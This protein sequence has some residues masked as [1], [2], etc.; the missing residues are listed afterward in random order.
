MAPVMALQSAVSILARLGSRALL[1]ARTDHAHEFMFQSSPD[2][3]VGRY[4]MAC[5]SRC[6]DRVVSILARLG[7]RALRALQ[8]SAGITSEFQSSPDLGVGR[9]RTSATGIGA[10]HIVSILARLGSRALHEWMRH[11]RRRCF[12]PRPTW[13]SGATW[14]RSWRI[15]GRWTCFNPRP[16]W[17][18]ALRG[19]SPAHR[20][21]WFQSS[22]D[23]GVGRYAL[24]YN[25]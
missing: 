6:S 16:T 9:Y 11:N 2:L 1:A 24:S 25:A 23:L 19:T 5:S 13:E 14:S 3:G 4:I 20:S 21:H 15:G 8:D 10:E 12:N 22:P 17:S 18:R 7:S